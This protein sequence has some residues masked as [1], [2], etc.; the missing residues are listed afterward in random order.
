MKQLAVLMM[1]FVAVVF[2]TGCP[3]KEPEYIDLGTIPEKYLATVPYEDGQTFYLQ[4]ESDRVVIPFHVTRHRVKAQGNNVW[5]FEYYGKYKPMPSVF[6]DYE[7][8]VTTCK[9]DYPIFDIEIR[10]S[11]AYMADSVYYSGYDPFS[12][13]YAQLSLQNLLNVSFPFIGESTDQF[14]VLDSLDINGHTYNNVFELVNPYQ[15][16]QGIYAKTAYYNFE[17]GV[18]ALYLSNGEKFLLY[19]EE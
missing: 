11:N 4:H 1:A 17:K 12:P 18:I 5:G 8:D 14:T 3:S 7:M 16:E 10:F 9:P 19:E 2:F 13:K 15:D 6:F